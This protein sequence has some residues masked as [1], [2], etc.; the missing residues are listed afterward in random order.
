MSDAITM[1]SSGA[2]AERDRVADDRVDVPVVGDVLGLAVVGAERHPV[3]PVLERERQQRAQVARARGLAD[4][5]PEPGAQPLAALLERRRLVVRLDPGRRVGVQRLAGDARRMAVDV[6]RE[7][8]LRELAR[9]EPETT[10]GK[11][12]ISASPSTCLRRSSP[13]RS[14]VESSRRGDSK[15][16]GRDARG[17]H[18]VDVERQPGARRRS[19]QWTPSVP[20][21]FAISCGSA[22]IAVVPSG[23]TSR[24]N[25]SIR[26]FDDSMCRCGSMKPGT[27]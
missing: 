26:S 4:Q 19:S 21:T 16:G 13:S 17:G 24:A 8:E 7:P 20:R 11:F 25:S 5:Q 1:A 12:I 14:P 18:E 2:S 9:R 23:S 3:G 15:R 22:T 10:P 27:R 6:P